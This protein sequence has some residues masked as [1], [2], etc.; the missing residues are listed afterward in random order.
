MVEIFRVQ[1]IQEQFHW[2]D[3]GAGI[4]RWSKD[5]LKALDRKTRKLLKIYRPLHPQADVDRLYVKIAQGGRGLI[6]AE[7]CV[8]IDVG[9]F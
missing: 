8:N 7:D 2:H 5:E 3:M 9:S 4:I 1:L 6:G